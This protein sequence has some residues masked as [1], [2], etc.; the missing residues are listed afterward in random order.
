MI[1]NMKLKNCRY[2]PPYW[3]DGQLKG[4][5]FHWYRKGFWKRYFKKRDIKKQ[6]NNL[7]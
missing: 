3:D 5:Y 6:L 4:K 2:K 7:I 1:F